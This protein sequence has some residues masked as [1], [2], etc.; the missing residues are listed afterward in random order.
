MLSNPTGQEQSRRRLSDPPLDLGGVVLPLRAMFGKFRQFRDA[1]GK[2]RS[3]HRRLQ[4]PLRNE[5][6]EATVRRRGVR[7]VLHRQ[8]EVSG[9]FTAWQI[10]CVLPSPDE[11]DHG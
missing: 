6:G 8:T 5:I 2:R 7:V 11:L 9:R 3:C 4:E 10:E 1:V